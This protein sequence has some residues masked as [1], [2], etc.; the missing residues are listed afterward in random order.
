MIGC[1]K[2]TLYGLAKGIGINDTQLKNR[3]LK[4]IADVIPINLYR[5]LRKSKLVLIS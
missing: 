3:S 1:V 5:K 4:Y 2:N